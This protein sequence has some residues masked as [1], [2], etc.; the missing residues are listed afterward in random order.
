MAAN[1]THVGVLDPLGLVPTR[2]SSDYSLHLIWFSMRI[3]VLDISLPVLVLITH[4]LLYSGVMWLLPVKL[5]AAR[6]L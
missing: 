2:M 6:R 5:F 3:R 1:R 4:A